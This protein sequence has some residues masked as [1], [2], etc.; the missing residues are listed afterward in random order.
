MQETL[1]VPLSGHGEWA[2]VLIGSC[3]GHVPVVSEGDVDFLYK[4]T[5]TKRWGGL[6]RLEG[7]PNTFSKTSMQASLPS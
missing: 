1:D 7:H 5:H 2:A 4:D 6:Q 3:P